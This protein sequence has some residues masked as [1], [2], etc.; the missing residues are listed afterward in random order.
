MTRSFPA[1]G[2]H[3]Y[4]RD[5]KNLECHLFDPVH[6]TLEDDGEVIATHIKSFLK[7]HVIQNRARAAYACPPQK[8]S[9]FNDLLSGL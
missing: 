5:V 3:P 8:L 7:R 4:K 1:V 2:T 9:S 6:C